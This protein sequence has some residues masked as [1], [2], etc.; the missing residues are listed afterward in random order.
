[1]ST[2]I[3]LDI[4]RLITRAA[5]PVP[6]GIDRVELAY[7]QYLMATEPDR[8][9]F[10][11]MHPL[12]HWGLLPLARARRFVELTA[13]RW[14]SPDLGLEDTKRAATRLRAALLVGGSSRLVM[15]GTRSL[16]RRTRSIYLLTSHHHLNRPKVIEATLAR[17]QAVFVCFVHDLIPIEFPEYA[18]PGEPDRHRRRIETVARLS[19]GIITNS[20]ATK[21]ALQ[22]WLER[23]GRAPPVVVAHL[24]VR[25]AQPDTPPPPPHPFFVCIGTIEPRKNHLLL[26]N[27]WRRLATGMAAPPHLV[28]IGRRGWE[29]ENVIDMIE[30]CR[31]LTGIVEERNVMADDDV[32]TLLLGAR[33]LLL[34]SFAEGFGLPL[35]EAL[36]L[37]VPAIC[38]DVVALR[39]VGGDVPEFLDPLDGPAWMAAILDY[40]QP[41]SPRRAAQVARLPGW[42]APTWPGHMA[43]AM[44]LLDRL[45]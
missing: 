23:A 42:T 2:R 44:A 45:K 37:R 4:S 6:T 29:N 13:E 9:Q 35:A 24:G 7:A 43:T 38:S 33:A 10:G 14:A 25:R 11:A 5:E 18:R 40:A 34:P 39:E 27:L 26:L 21:H 19:D 20:E 36:A 12:G 16:R 22:P 15:R 8:L 41:H 17:E 32:R 31:A 30:R 3:I 28:V 1:M